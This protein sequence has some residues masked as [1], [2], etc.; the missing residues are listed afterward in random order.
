[1]N[2]IYDWESYMEAQDKKGVRVIGLEDLEADD[3]KDFEEPKPLRAQIFEATY[4]GERV[5]YVLPA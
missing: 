2:S 1:M 5:S 3:D 4:G